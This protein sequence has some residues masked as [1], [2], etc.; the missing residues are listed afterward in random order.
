MKQLIDF[1]KNLFDDPE[2]RCNTKEVVI[3]KFNQGA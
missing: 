3:S 2:Y 1:I